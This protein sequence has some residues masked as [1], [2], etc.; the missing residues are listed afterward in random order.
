MLVYS[1]PF[2]PAILTGFD[3]QLLKYSDIRGSELGAFEQSDSERLEELKR[4]IDNEIGVPHADDPSQCRLIAFGSKPC[5]GP[6]TYLV[7]SAK[8]NESR[9][10]QL[11]G[12]Y[13]QVQKRINIERKLLSNCAIARKPKVEYVD[14]V[15]TGV[16]ELK[17]K[18]EEWRRNKLK[19]SNLNR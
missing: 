7:Y 14:G 8:T 13:N 12:E 1:C 9:L 17:R 5:G 3:A 11:V 2:G 4:L 18:W 15:C 10:E 16:D 19:E 6:W